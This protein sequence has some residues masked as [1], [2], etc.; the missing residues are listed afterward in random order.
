[1]AVVSVKVQKPGDQWLSL[2]GYDG[3]AFVAAVNTVNDVRGREAGLGKGKLSELK[4]RHA[5]MKELSDALGALVKAASKASSDLNALA[6][7]ATGADA[8]RLA[9]AAAQASRTLA[10]AGT[11]YKSLQ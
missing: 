8:E 3:K 11:E 10:E 1:M 7:K 9:A 6:K 5:W 4:D 2:P